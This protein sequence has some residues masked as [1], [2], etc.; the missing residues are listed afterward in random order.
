MKNE[1][2]SFVFRRTSISKLADLIGDGLSYEDFDYLVLDAEGA[3]VAVEP[4]QRETAAYIRRKP[5]DI[6]VEVATLAEVQDSSKGEFILS[7]LLNDFIYST[8]RKDFDSATGNILPSGYAV[9]VDYLADALTPSASGKVTK[10]GIKNSL[11]AEIA[12]SFGAFLL[13]AG[14][15]PNAVQFQLAFLKQ[16]FEPA[17]MAALKPEQVAAIAN[18]LVNWAES[19][20]DAEASAYADAVE[21]LQANLTSAIEGSEEISADDL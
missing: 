13:Q 12:K 4:A 18:N 16:K 2:F 6:S 20:S 14:K 3:E 7:R 10:K 17:T 15:K 5:V 1:N 21:I 8:V 9:T 11:L 19:L